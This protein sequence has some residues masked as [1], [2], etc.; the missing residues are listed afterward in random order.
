MVTHQIFV[1]N[2]KCAGCINTIKDGLQKL[3]GV[4]A[5]DVFKEENKVCITGIAIERQVMADKMLSLG[6]PEKGHNNFFSK[7]KSFVT[8]T[9][10]KLS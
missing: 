9:I 6:Y 7:A 10:D 5:V 3:P 8:C 1:E 4:I 2:I